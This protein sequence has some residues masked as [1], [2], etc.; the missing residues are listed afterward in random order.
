MI[1][2]VTLKK[3]YLTLPV[4]AASCGISIPDQE[5]NQAPCTENVESFNHWTTREVSILYF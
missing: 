2:I 4:L 3:I 5:S 1:Y